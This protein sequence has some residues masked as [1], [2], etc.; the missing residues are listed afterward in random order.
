METYSWYPCQGQLTRQGK[1]RY[2]WMEY[3]V[4]SVEGAGPVMMLVL[5]ADSWDTH[6]MV[7]ISNQGAIL[8]N[9][10]FV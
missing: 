7:C 6:F 4:I 1:W 2:V 10:A 8:F 9:V 3:G 5:C